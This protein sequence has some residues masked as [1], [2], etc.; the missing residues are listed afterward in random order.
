MSTA[1]SPHQTIK[2]QQCQ[3]IVLIGLS[4]P[5]SSGKTTV[6]KALNCLFDNSILVHLDDFYIPDEQI[7]VDPIHQE[8]DWD[9]PEAI[10]FDKFVEYIEN[11]K[12]GV[13]SEVKTLESDV[14]LKLSK[15]EISEYRRKIPSTPNTLYVFVDGFMLF[16]DPKIISLFDLKLFFYASFD[17]LKYRR[18]SRSGYNTEAGFWVDP[19]NYFENIVWPQYVKNHNYLFIDNDVNK[20]LNTYAIKDLGLLS[21]QNESKTTLNDLIQWS[22]D[23]ILN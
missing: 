12:K 9:C 15:D 20:E 21:Y 19:P 17:T 6:A 4:G 10:D 1:A 3:N 2:F 13:L 11:I 18:E 16:H 7:P 8:K 5:S 23:S 14:T 22:I